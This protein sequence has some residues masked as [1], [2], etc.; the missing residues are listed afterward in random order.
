MISDAD[1]DDVFPWMARKQDRTSAIDAKV[2]NL[3]APVVSSS[4]N[5]LGGPET[6]STSGPTQPFELLSGSNALHPDESVV[7]KA[8]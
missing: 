7:Q 6:V 2:L 3:I 8:A 1:F 5:D 4:D